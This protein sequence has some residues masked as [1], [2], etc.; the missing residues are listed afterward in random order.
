MEKVK[1]L[2]GNV[3]GMKTSEPIYLPLPLDDALVLP[4]ILTVSNRRS[5]QIIDGL[6]H[7]KLMRMVLYYGKYELSKSV[8]ISLIVRSGCTLFYHKYNEVIENL[9]KCEYDRWFDSDSIPEVFS[10]TIQFEQFKF[11][12]ER[13]KITINDTDRKNIKRWSKTLDCTMMDLCSYLILKAIS[14][15][16]T[17]TTP[18]NII[19][20]CVEKVTSFEQII[21]VVIKTRTEIL[22]IKV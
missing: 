18:Q 10:F 16:T 13:H 15:A 21:D 22:K 7:N 3:N 8:V 6:E 5:I 9:A 11:G 20:E 19:D 17:K 12:T 1:W 14:S 2:Y 4:S